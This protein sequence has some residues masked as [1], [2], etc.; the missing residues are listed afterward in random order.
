MKI[1]LV[2]QETYQDLY[3]CPTKA[4]PHAKILSSRSR[5]GPAGLFTK[6]NADFYTVRIENTPEC[7]IWK[8][9]AITRPLSA[10]LKLREWHKH[11]VRCKDVD[12]SQYDIVISLDISVPASITK[13]CRKTLWCYMIGELYM[14]AYNKPLI[15]G[16]DAKLNQNLGNNIATSFGVVDFPYSF[17]EP[18]SLGKLVDQSHPDIVPKGVFQ[19]A[20]SVAAGGNLV[21][22]KQFGP[23]R[24]IVKRKH[25]KK[26]VLKTLINLRKSKY[27]VKFGGRNVRGNGVVEAASCGNAL[28]MNHTT[29][30]HR[31]LVHPFCRA[32]NQKAAEKIINKLEQ[33]KEMLKEVVEYQNKIMREF[34]IGR[35]MQSL[36]NL[37]QKK[38]G[39]GR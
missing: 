23:I 2:K 28:V 29:I 17:I 35:P 22:L 1:A 8:Q 14:A 18:G 13:K 25:D 24:T 20:N 27:F 16:Y 34:V 30:I 39:H 38:V 19:E 10:Y 5:V 32:K 33:D 6:Y 36:K 37:H 26:H 15:N 31:K 21:R 7:R 4:T 11:V 9:K 12:W 3:N